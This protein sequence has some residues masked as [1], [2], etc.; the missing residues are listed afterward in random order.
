[1]QMRRAI[2]TSLFLAVPACHRSPVDL[3][4]GRRIGVIDAGGTLD[5]VVDAPASVSNNQSFTITISTFGGSCVTAAGADVTITDLVATITPYDVVSG[6]ICLDY[7]KPY[8]RSVE[9]RFN[10]TGTAKTQ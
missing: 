7:L 3:G 10:R 1:M 6:G 9:L 5:R 2:L 8:P 4:H